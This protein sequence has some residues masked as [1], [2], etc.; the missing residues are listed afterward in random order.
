MDRTVGTLRPLADIG[1]RLL[2]ERLQ[3]NWRRSSSEAWWK[4]TAPVQLLIMLIFLIFIWGF[5]HSP[6]FSCSMSYAAMFSGSQ[7]I[8][9]PPPDEAHNEVLSW[10]PHLSHWAICAWNLESPAGHVC[11]AKRVWWNLGKPGEKSP[12]IFRREGYSHRCRPPWCLLMSHL[13]CRD[14]MVRTVMV[15]ISWFL[16]MEHR[17]LEKK[18]WVGN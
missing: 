17:L 18:S 10:C 5:H 16:Q 3:N 15:V 6:S 4:K 7:P 11:Q 13:S 9:H 14:S 2:E 8:R 1:G 12:L